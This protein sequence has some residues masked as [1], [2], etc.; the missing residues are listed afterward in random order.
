MCI[1]NTHIIIIISIIMI[2][3]IT[4]IITGDPHAR[5]HELPDGEPVHRQATHEESP[6]RQPFAQSQTSGLSSV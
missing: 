5:L 1:I 3:I 6:R 4:V 2:I